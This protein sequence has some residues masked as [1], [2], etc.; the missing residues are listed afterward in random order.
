VAQATLKCL[1][2]LIIKHMQLLRVDFVIFCKNQ[3]IYFFDK[4]ETVLKYQTFA[5]YFKI[6][7]KSVAVKS[8][9]ILLK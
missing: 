3:K 2:N 8:L 7:K 9:E 4:V 6:Y 1:N 5:R